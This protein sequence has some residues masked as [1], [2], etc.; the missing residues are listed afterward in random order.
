MRLLKPIEGTD[1]WEQG[2]R[3]LIA[4]AALAACLLTVINKLSGEFCQT[5]VQAATTTFQQAWSAKI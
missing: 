5:A 1:S 4:P 3:Y 2:R